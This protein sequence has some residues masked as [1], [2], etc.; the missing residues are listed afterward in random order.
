MG[1]KFYESGGNSRV[2]VENFKEIVV[3]IFDYREE[4]IKVKNIARKIL[5]F[6]EISKYHSKMMSFDDD[7]LHIYWK[8]ILCLNQMKDY[9]NQIIQNY[10][11][12]LEHIIKSIYGLNRLG[13]EHN[14]VSIDNIG[15]RDG[16]FVLY[17]YNMSKKKT[18]NSIENDIQKFYKS[19]D[20]HI[21]LCI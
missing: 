3:Q 16:Y 17:D 14:D 9:K 4:Y 15:M 12:M 5:E 21:N 18:N 6:P 2:R 1:I 7:K 19:I 8:K 20:F 13:Y 11:K 10:E